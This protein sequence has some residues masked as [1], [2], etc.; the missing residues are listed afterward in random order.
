MW[1]S[2]MVTVMVLIFYLKGK[3]HL[4]NV[5]ESHVHDIGKWIFAISF[6]WSYLWFFQFQLIWYA[7]IP[8]EGTYF[9]ARFNDYK[10]P[11]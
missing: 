9:V 2:A 6:L 11:F 4:T 1:V 10:L 8:E 7:N 5:N 3:G